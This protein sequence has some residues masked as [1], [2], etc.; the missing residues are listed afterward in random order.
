CC[1]DYV[2]FD[3]R[4]ET[5]DRTTSLMTVAR[6]TRALTSRTAN[7]SRGREAAARLLSNARFALPR[8]TRR[9]STSGANQRHGPDSE[10][11]P[12]PMPTVIVSAIS[13]ATGGL[14][15]LYDGAVNQRLV[16]W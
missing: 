5:V 6:A 8:R 4:D 15:C 1:L 14:R 2:A 16:A 10:Y 13:A 11:S 3:A 9:V 12:T 7:S